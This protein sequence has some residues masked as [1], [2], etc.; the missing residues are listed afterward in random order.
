[1]PAGGR[2]RIRGIPPTKR[3]NPVNRSYRYRPNLWLT[4]ID[5]M[6]LAVEKFGDSKG[7]LDLISV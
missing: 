7:R 6:G 4:L 5:T 3:E 2:G 1:V